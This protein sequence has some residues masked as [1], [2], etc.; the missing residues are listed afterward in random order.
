MDAGVHLIERLFL[1][2]DNEEEAHLAWLVCLTLTTRL[3]SS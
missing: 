3:P 2:T 1:E